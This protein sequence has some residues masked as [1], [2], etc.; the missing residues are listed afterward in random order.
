MEILQLTQTIAKAIDDKKG[1]DIKILD[2]QGLTEIADFFVIASGNTQSHLK[3]ICDFI[4]E[5][6]KE[7]GINPISTQGYDEAIWIVMDYGDIV[8]HL[9]NPESREYYQLEKF[10]RNAK[11]IELMSS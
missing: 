11:N 8:V 1:E 3:S 6:T 10:W 7:K 4:D 2:L 5:K 9:F